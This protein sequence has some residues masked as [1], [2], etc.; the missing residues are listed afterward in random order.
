MNILLAC[1]VLYIL[2]KP[3]AGHILT[4]KLLWAPSLPL[5]IAFASYVTNVPD[6]SVWNLHARRQNFH[7]GIACVICTGV[8]I[9]QSYMLLLRLISRML[10]YAWCGYCI[11]ECCS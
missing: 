4:C 9:L 5:P 8:N 10:W 3:K 2:L 11:C 1:R 6:G 7:R